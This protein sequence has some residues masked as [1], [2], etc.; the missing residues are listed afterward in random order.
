MYRVR[1][2]AAWDLVED[3][4]ATHRLTKLVIDDKIAEPLRN[5]VLKRVPDDGKIAYLL[6]C[7][8]CVSIWTGTAVS[9]ARHATP[10]LW[11]IAARAL[12]GS[13]VTGIIEEFV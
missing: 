10:R 12:A 13:S 1:V 6:T 8:W 9:I 11:R 2:A 3:A 5:E 7:P 4:L